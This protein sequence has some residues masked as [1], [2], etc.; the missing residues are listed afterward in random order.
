MK[1][2]VFTYGRMNPPHKG[3]GKLIHKVQEVAERVKGNYWVIVSHSCDNKDNPLDIKTKLYYLNKIFP[4]TKFLI[5][6][7]RNPTYMHFVEMFSD[8]GYNA[9]IMVVGEDRVSEFRKTLNKYNGKKYYFESI[10]VISAGRR[11]KASNSIEGISSTKMR[12]AAEENNFKYFAKCLPFRMKKSDKKQ[13]FNHVR[14][15]LPVY[16]KIKTKV[17]EIIDERISKISSYS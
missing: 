9:L 8:A 3:H 12:K 15:K 17:L 5:A 11:K 13:L 6:D 4:D 7:Q 10:K 2:I 14:A 16:T 1:T